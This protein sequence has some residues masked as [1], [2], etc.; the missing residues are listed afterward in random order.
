MVSVLSYVCVIHLAFS[1]QL[2]SKNIQSSAFYILIFVIVSVILNFNQALSGADDKNNH[3][4][5]FCS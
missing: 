1:S 4:K 3:F 5:S 2:S